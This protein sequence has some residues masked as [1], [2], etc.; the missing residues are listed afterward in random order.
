MGHGGEWL[1]QLA[2]RSVRKAEYDLIDTRSLEGFCC[3]YRATLRRIG[4]VLIPFGP[5]ETG[6]SANHPRRKGVSR[7]GTAGTNELWRDSDST[8]IQRHLAAGREQTTP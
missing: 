8:N 7:K 6:R 1:R 3:L 2:N 5:F 4:A